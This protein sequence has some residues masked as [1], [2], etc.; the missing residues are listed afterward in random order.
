VK[1]IVNANKPSEP[2]SVTFVNK[3]GEEQTYIWK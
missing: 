3:E 2:I 1:R